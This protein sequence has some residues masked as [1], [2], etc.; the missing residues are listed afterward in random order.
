MLGVVGVK[1]RGVEE[2]KAKGSQVGHRPDP[3]TVAGLHVNID[4][5]TSSDLLPRPSA[6]EPLKMLLL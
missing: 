6:A 2:C 1:G 5:V 3:V 4:L